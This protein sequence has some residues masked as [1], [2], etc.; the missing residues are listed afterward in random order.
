MPFLIIQIGLSAVMLAAYAWVTRKRQESRRVRKARVMF[1]L[2][3]I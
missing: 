1:F 2:E 3:R